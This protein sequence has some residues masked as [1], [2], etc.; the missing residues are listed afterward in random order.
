MYDS[1]CLIHLLLTLM[2]SH[3]ANFFFEGTAPSVGQVRGGS[4]RDGGVLATGGG[5]QDQIFQSLAP[6]DTKSRGGGGYEGMGP[7]TCQ[8]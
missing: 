2:S 7:P 4:S 6:S 1:G 5:V 8:V 3:R